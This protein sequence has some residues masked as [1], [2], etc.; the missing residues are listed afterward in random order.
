[1][2]SVPDVQ[3]A[4]ERQ[5]AKAPDGGAVTDRSD[6]RQRRRMAMA[7]SILTSPSG[8]MGTPATTAGAKTALGA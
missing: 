3:R 5:A 7:A 4:P 8:A 6:E 2:C 1:M